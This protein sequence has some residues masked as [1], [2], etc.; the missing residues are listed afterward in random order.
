MVRSGRVLSLG[1]WHLVRAGRY[2][3]R[4]FLWV[5]GSVTAAIL[6]QSESLLPSKH[7]IFIGK[8]MPIK[9]L[10]SRIIVFLKNLKG[11]IDKVI[12]EKFASI[13]L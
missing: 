7:P 1:S 5:D 4:V 12:E 13:F 3:N 11:K 6:L 8:S 9:V 10:K 2:G